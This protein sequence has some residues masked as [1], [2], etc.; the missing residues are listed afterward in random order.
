MKPHDRGVRESAM[1]TVRRL[2]FFTEVRRR[3]LRAIL[4]FLPT[5]Y[6]MLAAYRIIR[7][8]REGFILLDFGAGARGMAEELVLQPAT[9]AAGRLFVLGFFGQFDRPQHDDSACNGRD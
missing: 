4:L 9:I 7:G 8:L 2:S 3:E 5:A 1:K 6:L